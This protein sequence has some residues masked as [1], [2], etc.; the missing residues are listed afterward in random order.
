MLYRRWWA[1]DITS[2]SGSFWLRLYTY[3]RKATF[4][5]DSEKC[6]NI[7]PYQTPCFSSPCNRPLAT[8]TVV[9]SNPI[10]HGR[11]HVLPKEQA[12]SQS[13]KLLA[14]CRDMRRRDISFNKP[15][16]PYINPPFS[17]VLFD[18]L[19]RFAGPCAKTAPTDVTCISASIE[20]RIRLHFAASVATTL[21]IP[22]TYSTELFL[23]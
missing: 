4:C 6:T 1:W 14:P 12:K 18:S 7:L 9:P 2:L 8:A 22:Q 10:E 3:D 16:I 5:H 21:R 11:S 15:T 20:P 13:S 23:I 17:L 19:H